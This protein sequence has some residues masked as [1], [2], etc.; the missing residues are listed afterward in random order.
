LSVDL[1][2]YVFLLC[3]IQINLFDM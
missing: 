1:L 3:V 2:N